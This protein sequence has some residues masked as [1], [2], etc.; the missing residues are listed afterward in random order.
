MDPAVPK[1]HLQLANHLN[2]IRVKQNTF[3]FGDIQDAVHGKHRARLIVSPHHR[4]QSGVWTDCRLKLTQV[5]LPSRIHAKPGDLVSTLRQ[6]LASLQGGGM[7]HSGR[8]D[9]LAIP[10]DCQRGVDGRVGCFGPTA[11]EQ[12]LAWFTI[13]QTSY[14]LSGHFNRGAHLFAE[15][16]CAG[17]IAVKSG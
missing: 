10:V 15:A 17:G 6:N 1:A 16:I 7:L 13:K 2:G 3:G 11:R 8:D 14:S 12:D 5:N 9:M 4:Y